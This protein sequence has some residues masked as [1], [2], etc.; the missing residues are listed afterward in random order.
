MMAF[1]SEFLKLSA[2]NDIEQVVLCMPHRGRLNLLTGMLKFPPTTIFTKLAGMP[3]FPTDYQSTGD[4][5]SHCSKY[6]TM[7]KKKLQIL[8]VNCY[9]FI[10]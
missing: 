6:K 1:F 10:C 7:L 4:V 5:L 2:D 3:D 9:S 8:N